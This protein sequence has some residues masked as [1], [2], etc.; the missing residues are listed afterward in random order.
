[1]TWTVAALYK[2][3]SL[4]DLPKLQKTI[5]EASERLDIC[6]TLLL[7]PEGINGT[8][9]GVGDA[10]DEIVSLLDDLAD[11]KSGELKY[12]SA[13]ERPFRRMKVRL[14][15]E[16]ITMRQPEADP[17]KQVGTYVEP[18][19]WNT[20]LNDPDVVVLDTRNTYETAV[21]MFKGAVDPETRVF[22]EFSDFVSSNLDPKKN[23]KVA[24]YCTGG[25]RCEKASSYMLANGFEEVYHLKGGILQYLEDVK[26]EESLWDGACF[27]FDRRVAINHGLEESPHLLCY[28][29]RF[30]L[31]PEDTQH[32]SYEKGVSCHHCIDD[33][34]PEKAR[35]FRMRQ[36]QI[37]QQAEDT[38]KKSQAGS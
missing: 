10:L 20:I 26:P 3:V 14:K 11:I 9:A 21:G 18:K 7:A 27:V 8:I 17:T 29:C 36:A 5:R 23:K 38:R 24:M 34:T 1:M 35:A 37:D 15:K 33:L 2:F 25:I 32:P 4:D 30:P 12:S 22:T 31:Q 6:G 19:D 28:G 13:Q 16:I